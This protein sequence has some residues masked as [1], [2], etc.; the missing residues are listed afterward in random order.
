LLL[1][2][3]ASRICRRDRRLALEVENQLICAAALIALVGK[4]FTEK[5]TAIALLKEG[6]VFSIRLIDRR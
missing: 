4:I 2:P 6:M 1:I 5:E 3:A